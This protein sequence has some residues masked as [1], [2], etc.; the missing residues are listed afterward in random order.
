MIINNY[1]YNDFAF[2]HCTW[3]VLGVS[4]WQVFLVS[5]CCL[6]V[7]YCTLNVLRGHWPLWKLMMLV[8]W[9]LGRTQ[10]FFTIYFIILQF[11]SSTRIKFT[12]TYLLVETIFALWNVVFKMCLQHS[13]QQDHSL[14]NF[15]QL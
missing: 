15:W 14:H 2:V 4:A 7:R 10:F 3:Y 6:D 12:E 5:K 1:Y 11:S 13:V 8:I 9:S